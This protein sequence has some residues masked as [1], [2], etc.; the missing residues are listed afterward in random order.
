MA[1]HEY[2]LYF[3]HFNPCKHFI[4]VEGS[5]VPTHSFYTAS[6]VTSPICLVVVDIVQYWNR[7]KQGGLAIVDGAAINSLK[8]YAVMCFD[9]DYL[10][11]K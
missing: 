10:Y 5:S 1:V 11:L 7:A 3:C 8:A 9:K 6:F 4:S 2:I